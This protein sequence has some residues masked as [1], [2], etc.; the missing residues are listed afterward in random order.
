MLRD[1]AAGKSHKVD[2]LST[3][4]KDKLEKIEEIIAILSEESAKGKP[5]VVEGKKDAHALGELGINGKVLTL[6]TGGKS[7]IDAA[8]EI[9]TLGVDEVILLLDYDRRGKEGTKRLQQDLERAKVKVNARWWRKL[10]TLVAR[11]V[12]CI[13]SL[14]GY[15]ETLKAKAVAS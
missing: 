1:G 8:Q 4:L 14:P 5:I 3:R 7:F 13:E 10:Q 2:A 6:K 15:L 11:E 9:E 12:Q